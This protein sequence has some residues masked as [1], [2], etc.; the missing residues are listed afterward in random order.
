MVT[1][2][3]TNCTHRNIEINVGYDE[4]CIQICSITG[5]T[6]AFDLSCNHEEA[7]TR[8]LFHAKDI[9]LSFG[10]IIIHTPDTDVFLIALSVS[11][12]FN[13]ELFIK[14]GTENTA[15]V[16][17]L[18][19]IKTAFRL[20]YELRDMD[21]VSKALLGVHS[22]TGCDT[23]SSFSSKGKVKPLQLMV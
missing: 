17:S 7:D 22:F 5:Q 18:N 6:R 19:K 1:R 10:R 20:K 2:W 15:Y 21:L 14:T 16:I 12:Q 11:C 13:E 4:T 9:S 23:I 3:S 8:L